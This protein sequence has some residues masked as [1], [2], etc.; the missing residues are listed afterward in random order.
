M[1]QRTVFLSISLLLLFSANSFAQKFEG[2]F[3][4]EVSS[5]KMPNKTT[6]MVVSTKGDKLLTSME[7]Q[8]GNIKMLTDLAANKYTMIMESMKMG[9][10]MPMNTTKKTSTDTTHPTIV[11]TGDTKTISGHSCQL[12]KVTIHDQQSNWW[13]TGDVPLSILI[14]LKSLYG[15]S[16]MSRIESPRSE[17]IEDMFKK[18]LFPIQVETIN[19]GKTVSTYTFIKY[20]EKHLDDS[21]FEIP[22]D[23]KIQQMPAM[24]GMGGRE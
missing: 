1:K 24:G 8:R 3:T 20:E 15:N 14:A 16:A 12:Y 17:A 5:I 23:I 11:Q 13:M 7:T 6:T 4:M 10:E 19:D 2:V 22:S 21:I 18:G 9:M